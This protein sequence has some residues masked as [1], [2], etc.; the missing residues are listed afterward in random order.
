MSD[1]SLD[2]L[3]E[4]MYI[5][6]YTMNNEPIHVPRIASGSDL[7]E[8]TDSIEN[9]II[10]I[11]NK[12][13]EA[14]EWHARKGVKCKRLRHIW[15]LPSIIIPVL[16]TALENS[17]Y[18]NII[19]MSFGL[20]LA[21]ICSAIEHLFNWGKRSSDH[22]QAKSKYDALVTDCEEQLALDRELRH[23]P[24]HIMSQIK[25]QFDSFNSHSPAY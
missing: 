12:S 24:T 2:S 8:W 15:G 1:W 9:Y 23:N 10:D 14:S 18:K 19:I 16:L 3:L 22:F 20:A 25:M 13:N 21:T 4:D 11:K 5:T 7:Q 6:I 17:N